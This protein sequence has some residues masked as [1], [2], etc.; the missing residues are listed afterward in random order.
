M[1]LGA[2]TFNNCSIF[3]IENL[4]DVLDEM[5][6]LTYH[7]DKDHRLQAIDRDT[8]LTELRAGCESLKNETTQPQSNADAKNP[9]GAVSAPQQMRS[10]DPKNP[11][12][13]AIDLKIDVAREIN[14]IA[15]LYR[16]IRTTYSVPSCLVWMFNLL[17]IS[18][19]RSKMTK[20]LITF[21]QWPVETRS[22][23]Y[24]LGYS[25]VWSAH[26]ALSTFVNY[27]IIYSS[28]IESFARLIDS[29]HSNLLRA[30]LNEFFNRISISQLQNIILG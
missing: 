16:Y 26:A 22:M 29:L 28:H 25:L 13:D 17:L 15:T 21:N 3:L 11:I 1:L 7:L 12:S 10:Q 18:Y 8:L 14:T 19:A 30:H 9:Q 20:Q 24:W 27:Y 23:S 6:D 4:P 5:A 2:A